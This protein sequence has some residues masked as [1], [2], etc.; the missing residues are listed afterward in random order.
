MTNGSVQWFFD[1]LIEHR[2]IIV[3]KTTYQ[4]KY[5][6]EILL[7]Q[8][9]EMHKQE[10][11]TTWDKSMDNL[12]ARGGNIVRAWVDF[13]DYYKETYGADHIVDTN[14]MVTAVEWLKE[15]ITYDNGNGERCGSFKET[16]DL[17]E[18]FNEANEMEIA[19]K[20]MSYADGYKEGYKRA[21]EL[22]QW[23]ISNLVPSQKESYDRARESLPT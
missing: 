14:K 12:D 3:D 22:T 2:I 15:E 18:Y 10:H 9:K 4:V 20:E 1:Q 23:A 5:K 6:H 13:D 11:A 21:L 8:A 16:I 17:T 7:E 19:G